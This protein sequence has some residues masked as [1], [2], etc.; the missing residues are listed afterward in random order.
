MR[1]YFVFRQGHEWNE[2]VSFHTTRRSA[3]KKLDQLQ[4]ANELI[5]KKPMNDLS[6][7]EL[8]ERMSWYVI[9]S[10]EETR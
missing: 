8:G 1:G 4:A 3:K 7:D 10:M 2:L 9:E 5:R 6:M